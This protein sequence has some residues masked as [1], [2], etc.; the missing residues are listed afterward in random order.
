MHS[1]NLH[2]VNITFDTATYKFSSGIERFKIRNCL[3]CGGRFYALTLCFL[4]DEF[5]KVT[6]IGE[7]ALG[8]L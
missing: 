2:C 8:A 4:V 7:A 3:Q 6:Q 1:E 5:H